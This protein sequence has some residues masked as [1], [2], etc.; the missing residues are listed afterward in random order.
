MSDIVFDA[1]G[2]LIVSGG[3]GANFNAPGLGPAGA[4]PCPTPRPSPRGT[5]AAIRRA[6]VGSAMTQA[7]GEGGALRSQ[8]IRTTGRP[9]RAERDCHPRQP[10]QR[11]RRPCRT[12]PVDREPTSDTKRII[13][14]GLR[15]PFRMADPPGH[16]RAVARRRGLGHLGGDQSHRSRWMSCRN[17]GWP[18]REGTS[19]E[20]PDGTKPGCATSLSPSVWRSPHHTSRTSTASGGRRGVRRSRPAPSPGSPSTRA[21]R[22]PDQYDNALF[23]TDYSRQCLW[24]MPRREPVACRTPR[25]S[26]L[27]PARQ[28][29]HLTIGPDG[30]LF[31][32]DFAVSGIDPGASGYLALQTSQPDGRHRRRSDKRGRCRWSVE[33]DAS[34]S[35][36]PDDD[37]NLT[38][39]WDFGDNDGQV[40]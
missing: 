31:Y 9:A 29:V 30:D 14:Y 11:A 15:N 23:F 33:F 32:V 1:E 18:C 28:P 40:Q 39:A 22:Y 21:V 12:I 16:R 6:G 7:T 3:D 24:V 25:R 10:A 36:D 27:R 5:R 8:D 26:R 20:P 17:F 37:E 34:A 2:A 38:Y 13:A 35:S 19:F 4:A